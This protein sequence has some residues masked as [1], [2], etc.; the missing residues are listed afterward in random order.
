MKTIAALTI[1]PSPYANTYDVNRSWT[2]GGSASLIG[3]VDV[4][5]GSYTI[6]N[7]GPNPFMNV[8][9]TLTINGT[10]FSLDHANTFLVVGTGQFFIDAT[11]S[12]LTFDTANG[13]ASNPA[14]LKFFD[15]TNTADY[16]IGSDGNPN[17]EAG[18][19]PGDGVVA[20]VSFPVVWGTAVSSVP[21]T[22]STLAMLSVS[23]LGLVVARQ[24]SLRRQAKIG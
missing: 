2:G 11:A 9:L 5:A 24:R 14:D 6:M 19:I 15:P 22:G 12:F 4:A 3:T 1:A 18:Y 8:N 7:G 13:D 10:A 23:L 17:F 20:P 16:L 21:D